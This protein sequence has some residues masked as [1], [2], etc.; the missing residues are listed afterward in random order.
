MK[1]TKISLLALLASF[2][3]TSCSGE[4][5][6]VQENMADTTEEVSVAEVIEEDADLDEEL[7]FKIDLIIGNNITGPSKVLSE[8]RT[9][10]IG[11]FQEGL[12]IP[13]D[14]ARSFE[15]SSVTKGLALG[16]LGVDVT[17]LSVYDRPDLAL[18]YIKSVN[19]L[20]IDLD[21]GMVID[22]E[23][24]AA[25][26]EAKEDG[27]KMSQLMY[28]Q[29]FMME[30][31]LKSNA[32]LEVAANVM[33]GGIMESLFI[34][35]SQLLEVE[36]TSE[37]ISILYGQKQ[38]ISDLIAVYKDMEGNESVID[39]LVSVQAVFE[40]S[41]AEFTKEDLEILQGVVKAFHDEIAE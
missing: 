37:A 2:T 1:I 14:Q 28:D 21:C 4:N 17:Y 12:V 3:F 30:D 15:G 10:E 25:F 31:Y 19:D 6:D 9:K 26:E 36:M 39:A 18:K 41:S 7:Q 13:M 38:A 27:D 23:A 33:V 11:R 22:K 32:K 40:K 20:N 29:Y 16:A 24:S 35:T 5:E 34:S 8:V